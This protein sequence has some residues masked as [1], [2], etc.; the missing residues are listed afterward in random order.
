MEGWID[1]DSQNL[2][3]GVGLSFKLLPIQEVLSIQ[4]FLRDSST[5]K[6]AFKKSTKAPLA[7]QIHNRLISEI[8]K[9][10]LQNLN[11]KFFFHEFYV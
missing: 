4:G 7:T 1:R 11:K 3:L 2:N 10:L 9:N 6:S 5:P 8:R